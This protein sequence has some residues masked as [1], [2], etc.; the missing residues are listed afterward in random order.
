M[1]KPLLKG[2]FSGYVQKYLHDLTSLRWQDSVRDPRN[3]EFYKSSLLIIASEFDD[4]AAAFFY[5]F[6]SVSREH[7][8]L[9]L[10]L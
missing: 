4:K 8:G 9:I 5:V 2:T 7:F 6:T 3:D 10:Q 1:A